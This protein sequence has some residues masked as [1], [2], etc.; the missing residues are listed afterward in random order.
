[1]S[2]Q[3]KPKRETDNSDQILE[4]KVLATKTMRL[5]FEVL[6]KKIKENIFKFLFVYKENR[7]LVFKY[8]PCSLDCAHF[9]LKK[10][11]KNLTLKEISLDFT[12]L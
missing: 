4:G 6:I 11:L 2:L 10:W 8:G 1:M 9:I 3:P 7:Y 5:Q 12:T